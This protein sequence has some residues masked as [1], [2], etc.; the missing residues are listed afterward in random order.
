M[1]PYPLQLHTLLGPFSCCLV[2]FRT[3]QKE[4]SDARC[5]HC[6]MRTASSMP[7]LA[8]EADRGIRSSR[9]RLA[10]PAARAVASAAH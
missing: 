9:R 4:S 8:S 7:G 3:W 6:G 1:P 5:A 10:A 2:R